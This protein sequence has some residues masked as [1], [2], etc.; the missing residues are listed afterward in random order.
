[1][2]LNAQSIFNVKIPVKYH[3]GDRAL[4]IPRCRCKDNNKIQP[5]SKH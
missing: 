1:M 4:E 2:G 5:I 3:Q